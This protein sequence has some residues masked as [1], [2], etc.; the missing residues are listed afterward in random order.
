MHE[1]VYRGSYCVTLRHVHQVMLDVRL[2]EFDVSIMMHAG[3]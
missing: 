3:G 2:Y 1:I